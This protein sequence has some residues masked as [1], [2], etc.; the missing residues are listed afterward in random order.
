MGVS[1]DKSLT[2]ELGR[3]PVGGGSNVGPT[4]FSISEISAVSC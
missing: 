3:S 2:D 4:L 1:V